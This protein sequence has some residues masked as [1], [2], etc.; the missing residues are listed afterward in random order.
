[1]SATESAANEQHR[2]EADVRQI[3]HLVTHSLYSDR[4][5]F[6]R[7]LVSNASDAL[8]RARFVALSQTDLMEADGEP[9]VRIFVDEE[10][11]TITFSDDGIGLTREQAT[12]H[13][14][15]IAK[16]GTK[17]FAQ[18]LKD[19]GDDAEGL[20]GQF[21]VGFYSA[22][23][24]ADKVTVK[25]LSGM[26]GSEAIEW[27]SDGGEAYTLLPGDRS[28]RGTDVILHLREDSHDFCSV[29]KLKEIVQ[30]HSDF[31]SWPVMV[32]GERA[33]QE[34]ALWTRSPSDL[35][36]ED[37]IQFYK[38]VSGDW[39]DPLTW[40]HVKVE[41]NIQFSAVLFVPRKRPWELD[42]LDFKVGLKLYQK[43]VKILDHADALVPRY[44]RFVTGVVDSP[45]V[46]LNVSREILQQTGVVRTIRKQLTKR[47]L[48]KMR[49]LSRED[50]EAFNGFWGEMGHILKEGLHEDNEGVQ[51]LL[52]ELLRYPTTKSDGELKS[53]ADIKAAFTEKQDTLWYF[54][55]VDKER[56]ADAPV[57]EGFKKRDLEVMLMSDP[58]DEWVVMSVKEFDGTELKSAMVGE[59][60]DEEEEE[61]PIAKAAKE[62]AMPLVTW[63]KGLL[64]GDVAEVR[65]SNRLTSSPSVLVD[66][67]GAMGSNLQQIL[68]AANQQ[69]FASKRVLEV[70]PE[71]PMVKT[72]ARLNNE[73]ATG[74]EPFARLL[75]D[76][77]AIAE[78]RLDDP[79]GF[80]TRL[81]A[82][83]S[84]AAEGMGGG[85][86]VTDAPAEGAAE[87]APEV[88]V[89]ILG[90]EG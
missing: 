44:L 6:V 2:F 79:K 28:T 78:G 52:T 7:E 90:E 15:T 41:G 5:I 80:A 49:S 4:E 26:P 73:G 68:K 21:G 12:E 60:D 39:Q 9:S 72:L 27:E 75:L 83:M 65:L 50:A 37:Y 17:A 25:S 53:L 22:F 11:K 54:T 58:V 86:T 36:D 85:V 84:R 88:N 23:M 43:R 13:L 24:V 32:D 74:L 62:Q 77:A 47:I 40:L 19:K 34:Q 18:M 31:V 61:D 35:E 48:K 38:H 67:E 8:D 82:L 63:M 33:N 66:Q 56:I 76:H 20:I 59:F 64:D 45:D 29:E 55:S 42:R 10:A 51:D 87:A 46:D 14:G 1:M 71:H 30:K 3:L 70:N 16:S 69:V 89:E 81:Q 57:L